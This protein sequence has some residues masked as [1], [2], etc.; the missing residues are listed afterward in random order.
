[1]EKN[2]SIAEDVF[3]VGVNDRRTDLFEGMWPLPRGVSYNSYLINDEKVALTDTVK[4]DS[5][6]LFLEKI[7]NVLGDKPIDYL[8]IHHLEPD[9]SGSIPIIRHLYPDIKIIG[10]AKTAEFLEH[11]FGIT[12][13]VQIVKD[14]D[15][16]NL[17]GRTLKF[18]LTPMVHWP[19]T[20]MTYDQN[21]GVLFSGDAF[22]GF[23]TLDGDIFDD[24]LDIPYFEDEI[25][26]YFSN[27]V[28]KF[29][30]PVQKA[31][32]KLGGLDIKVIAA[33]HGPIWR[34]K[35]EEIIGLYAKWGKMEAEPGVVIAY[36]SMYGSTE[37]MMEAVASGVVEAG[38]AEVRVHDLSRTH[39]SY[40]IRDTWRYKGLILGSPTYDID[41]FPPVKNF[42]S[43]LS[44][45][46]L[47]N[48]YVGVF[49]SY[50]WSGGAVKNLQEFAENSKMELV[51]PIV[52]SRFTSKQDEL[53]LCRQLGRNIAKSVME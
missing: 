28:G 19:E 37:K 3:W 1:M 33:T 26:R 8:I 15:E 46:K 30:G 39:V 40:V 23:G 13:D 31:L 18:Y 35:P 27:I 20:M 14:G 11:L 51:E 48:R 16:L 25:L 43:L 12:E 41:I 32:A 24:K 5:M 6:P 42:V 10:N 53:E 34:S 29:T 45:K 50:G 49:G 52:E 17:G 2:I 9:H 4:K 38:C 47:E 22:G 36:G 44:E 21:T 7:K